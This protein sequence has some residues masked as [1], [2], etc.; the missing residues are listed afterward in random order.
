MSIE[1]ASSAALRYPIQYPLRDYKFPAD[2][3]ID[4]V[5]FDDVHIHL[6]LTDGR[7]LSIPLKW[8]PPLYHANT[9]ERLKFYI[10]DDR[11]AVVW[12]PDE[13]EVNEILRLSDYIRSR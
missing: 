5:H 9:A 3:A 7:I 4:D 8:I 11:S 12:D 13:S 10:T 1:N 6:H 2:D